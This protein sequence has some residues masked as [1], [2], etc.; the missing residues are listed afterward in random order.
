MQAGNMIKL[1]KTNNDGECCLQEFGDLFKTLGIMHQTFNP[2][3]PQQNGVIKRVNLHNFWGCLLH[4]APT[5]QV[6]FNILG[7]KCQH[8][9]IHQ[10][11]KSAHV[12]SI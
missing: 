6:K 9:S 4:D 7:K 10:S 11:L 12:F 3:T 1:F 2:Y 5:T 8:I